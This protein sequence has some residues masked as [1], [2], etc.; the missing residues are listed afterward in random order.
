LDSFPAQA[1]RP[2]L[3][4]GPINT[5]LAIWGTVRGYGPRLALR[6]AGAQG[7]IVVDVE[8]AAEGK[9]ARASKFTR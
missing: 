8:Q 1:L 6:L 3:D 2:G 7:L 4:P 5:K 9:T